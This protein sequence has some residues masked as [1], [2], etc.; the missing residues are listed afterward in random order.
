[1]GAGPPEDRLT[2]ELPLFEARILEGL[3]LAGNPASSQTA[4][5]P[6]ETALVFSAQ[7]AGE[8]G[9]SASG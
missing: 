9:K 8:F 1:M 2:V 7:V 3:S 4:L 6:S 5:A